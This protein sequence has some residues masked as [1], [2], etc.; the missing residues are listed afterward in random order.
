MFLIK[1]LLK[2]VFKLFFLVIFL[3]L[4]VLAIFNWP[5]RG[6]NKNMEFNVS[7]SNLF[8]KQL[9]LD[10]QEAY[11]AI[12]NDLRPNKLRIAAYWS[13]IEKKPGQ[14]DFSDL[15][16]QIET[17]QD[18]NTDIILA[19]GQKTPRWPECHI[20][21]FYWDEKGKREEA[22]LAFERVLVE[23][24]KHYDNVKVWQVENEPF[25]PFGYCPEPTISEELVDREIALV[26]SIDGNRPIMVTDSGEISLWYK[27]A[28]RS[29]IFGTTMYKTIY[30][31]PF[32][33]FSYPIGPNF[34]RLKA[35]FVK[36]F[37]KQDNVIICEL[38][39]EPWGPRQIYDMKD[40]IEEQ[41]R[42]MNPEKLRSMAQFARRTNFSESY[43]WGAEW[44]Y[45]LKVQK[46]DSEMWETAEEIIN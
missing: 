23:R 25:L 41:Y 19:F 39:A 31:E 5:V 4:I 10:W 42:S 6:E 21:E 30:K 13:E 43:L 9:G 37:A 15:D 24:Y 14:Y 32:G 44:W 3:A 12:L 27:A 16:W 40:D 11:Q 18:K 1:W 38:Q 17:A 20:P 46:N 45:F 33:Y 2:L 36:F 28:G 22:L 8:A 34:F 35:L 29:D 26:R 7:F